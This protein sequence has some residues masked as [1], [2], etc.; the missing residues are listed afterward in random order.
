[1]KKVWDIYV[2]DW[3]RIFRSSS[4]I[5]LIVALMI[6]PSLYAWF[7]IKALWDPYGNTSGIQI[8]V[9]NDDEGITI[10]DKKMNVGQTIVDQL[11]NNTSLGWTFVSKKEA[12]RGVLYGDYYASIY[13]PKDFTE[14]LSSILTD[15]LQKPEIIYTYNDKINAIAPKITAKGATAITSDVTEKFISTVSEA[16]LSGFDEIGIQLDKDLPTIRNVEEKLY[17][18]RD[19]IPK[20]NDFGRK[21]LE[22]NAN[23]PVIQEKTAKILSFP[24]VFPKINEVGQSILKV[25]EAIPKIESVGEKVTILQQN[26]PTIRNI[27]EKVNEFNDDFDAV[28]TTLS[29]AI[30]QAQKA[31]EVIQSLIGILPEIEAVTNN[32]RGYVDV[33]TQFTD[34]LD[35]S[36]DSVA[37]IVQ[38]NLTIANS[39]SGSIVELTTPNGDTSQLDSLLNQLSIVLQSQIAYIQALSNQQMASSSLQT[40]LQKLQSAQNHVQAAQQA[41]MNGDTEKLYAEAA[42]MHN[43]T[44][45]ILQDYDRTYVPAIRNILTS[46]QADVKTAGNVVDEVQK[47]LPNVSEILNRTDDIIQTAI[48][49]LEKYEAALPQMEESIQKATS[50]INHNMDRIINGIT[51][52]DDFYRNRFPDVKDKVEKV[53]HFVVNDLPSL[54][55]K[56]QNAAQVVEDKLPSV[57]TAIQI[58]GNLAKNELPQLTTKVNETSEKLT[59]MK[60]SISLEEVIDVLRRDVKNDSEF[61]SSP[62]ELKEVVKFPIANYGSASTP[63]YTALAIWVGAILL[64]SMLSVDVEMPKEM[65]KPHHFYFGRGLTF[66]TIAFVQAAVVTLGDIFLLKADIHDKWEFVLFSLIICFVFTTI[67]YTLVSVFGN[68][69][70]GLAIILLVL[71]I[72][73][74]GGNFPIEVSSSFFQHLSPFLPFTYAVNLLREGVGGVLWQTAFECIIVLGSIGAL[75]LV[76]GTF[77]KKPLMKIVQRFSENAKKSKIIH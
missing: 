70:K 53:S 61:L 10:H 33:M 2:I 37:K 22:L 39:V 34:G 28:K 49:T 54:E 23:L 50:V 4:A 46:L 16:V 73:G 75:F 38:L 9:A 31:N 43:M 60:E 13:I 77:L 7:N 74:S 72:S 64:V 27:G 51:T 45:A 76:L 18:L 26:I 56:L 12:D 29:D 47:Q 71:Q 48:Q 41:L 1:M 32:G 3:R 57:I 55:E 65:Y 11:K 59:E 66:L 25:Q 17:Q 5:F 58:G 44:N 69:G 63:F 14:N 35:A 30:T 20:I 8:A 52:A 6:L 36:F 19:A 40:L 67:V 42:Q 68:I 62:I 24:D 21:V 15:H